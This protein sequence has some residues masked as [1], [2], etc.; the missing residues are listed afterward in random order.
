MH[1]AAIIHGR[2]NRPYSAFPFFVTVI[3]NATAVS[4][5]AIGSNSS[6]NF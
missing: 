5:N 4:S 1:L 6:M 3:P 2:Y